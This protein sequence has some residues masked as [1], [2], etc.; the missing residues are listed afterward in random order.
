LEKSI[1]KIL[2]HLAGADP[3][4]LELED[5]KGDRLF[6]TGLGLI[7]LM[8]SMFAFFSSAYACYTVFKN[9]V[10]A[11]GL[12]LFWGCCIAITDRFLIVTTVKTNNSHSIWELIPAS[13]RVFMAITVGIVIAAPLETAILHKEIHAEIASRN[14]IE[15][16]RMK[17][18]V[19]KLPESV[20]IA[21]LRTE[22][23]QLRDTDAKLNAEY[24]QIY[25]ST[26]GEAEGTAGTGKAGKGIVY[27]DK[28]IELERQKAILAKTSSQHAGQIARNETKVEQLEK[29]LKAT[30]DRVH[31]SR[32]AADSILAQI[33]TLHDMA[34][35]NPTVAWTSKLISLVFILVDV[36]PIIS[37]MLMPRTDYDAVKHRK[38]SEVIMRQDALIQNLNVR[39]AEEIR[40]DNAAEAEYS[41]FLEQTLT[42]SLKTAHNDPEMQKVVYQTAQKF[43]HRVGERLS[44]AID[45]IN[46]PDSRFK[47][48]AQSAVE[49]EMQDIAKPAAKRKVVRR[50]IQNQVADYTRELR[51]AFLKFKN[52]Y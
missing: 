38:R 49:R 2:W 48:E 45:S 27:T 42:D 51:Q 11:I 37:K 34:D 10:I 25:D 8:T 16:V 41:G 6:Y 29:T 5:C 17:E 30:T 9:P 35:K 44:Q 50:R 15:E 47:Q 21:R 13:I 23:Q 31:G 26:I 1:V 39:I 3:E 12:G 22:N 4:I 46:I 36:L 28:V 18:T 32:L 40:R 52:K 19:S 7:I 14:L 24:K 43:I 33:T 20:E